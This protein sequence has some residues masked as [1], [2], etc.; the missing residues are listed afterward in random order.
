MTSGPNNTVKTLDNDYVR[1]NPTK[2]KQIEHRKRILKRRR[3]FVFFI[4]AVLIVTGLTGMIMKQNDRIAVKEQEKQEVA[5]Q[6]Q[7]FEEQQELLKVQ[8]AKLD[9]EEYIAK[10]ARKEYFLSEAGEIIFTI[11]KNGDEEEKDL[12]KE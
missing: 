5:A 10:L 7:E 6:L 11:P 2:K 8:I 12:E 9:S 4:I 3:L 1:S